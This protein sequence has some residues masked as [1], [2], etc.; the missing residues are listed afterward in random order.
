MDINLKK[1]NG[2]NISVAVIESIGPHY[3]RFSNG[4]QIVY[5]SDKIT[6]SGDTIIFPVDFVSNPYIVFGRDA[7]NE[8]YSNIHG[9]FIDG[10]KHAIFLDDPV[11]NIQTSEV[12][13][14]YIAIGWWK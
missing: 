6:A 9:N 11:N 8:G 1:K 7:G 4:L 3:I 5:A 13:F 12:F 10:H 2:E 14:N